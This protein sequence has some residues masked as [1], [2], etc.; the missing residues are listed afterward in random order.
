MI[1]ADPYN[2]DDKDAIYISAKRGLG[3]KV[4]EGQRIAEQ[5]VFR[6]RSNA[7]QILT[8][9]EEDSLLTFDEKGGIKEVAIT[10]DRAVLSDAVI[11]KLAQAG[12]NIKRV[13]NNKDQDIEWVYM[14][15]QI[16]IVQARPFIPG[17]PGMLVNPG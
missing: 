7:V 6:P 1:P 8:K 11:R 9:S 5:V 12:Q 4:V 3:M 15:G 17:G 13:F 2:R 16:Y 14:D 10:G